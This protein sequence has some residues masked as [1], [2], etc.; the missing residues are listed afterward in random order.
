MLNNISFL[1]L[2]V[3]LTSP[4]SHNLCRI[5][6]RQLLMHS[7]TPPEPS[8]CCCK[9]NAFCCHWCVIFV[10]TWSQAVFTFARVRSRGVFILF[11]SFGVKGAFSFLFFFLGLPVAAIAA[12]K[13]LFPILA[14]SSCL[15]FPTGMPSMTR[16]SSKAS[17]TFFS[18]GRNILL[19]WA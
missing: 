10:W 6:Q 1:A 2:F 11:F 5:W 3:F 17:V 19:E 16:S 13:Q 7:I 4:G 9:D 15:L 14:A 12:P 8:F 18:K